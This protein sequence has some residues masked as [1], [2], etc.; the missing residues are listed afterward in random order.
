MK[1]SCMA[2]S[3]C[4]L[5]VVAGSTVTAEV[6]RT[7]NWPTILP[8]RTSTFVTSENS[9]VILDIFSEDNPSVKLY[10]LRCNNGNAQYK[11]PGEGDYS[12]MFQCHLLSL[13]AAGPDLLEGEDDW[14]GGKSYNTRGV[15]KYEQLIGPCN[16]DPEFGF[17]REFN[18]RGMK[19]ELTV[20]NF[21]S[22][23]IVDMITGKTEPRY[24]FDFDVVVTPNKSAM[25]KYTSPSAKKC[26]SGYYTVNSNGEAVYHE[27]SN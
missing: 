19:L 15:F 9:G 4:L 22:P 14:S 21:E 5:A 20:S 3:L 16:D 8:A 2:S 23:P 27:S 1:F 17:H 25:S 12:G 10:T 24:N 18:M 6:Y 13:C 11:I 7:T 26:C